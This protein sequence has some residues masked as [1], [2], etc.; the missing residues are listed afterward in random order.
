M[1]II[2]EKIKETL[3]SRKIWI[4]VIATIALFMG[5]I[6]DVTWAGM[7]GAYFLANVAQKA[8]TKKDN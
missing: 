8:T 1:K 3:L 7:M 2:L 6:G 4:C 5:K